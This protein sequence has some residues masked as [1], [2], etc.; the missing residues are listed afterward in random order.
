MITEA[1][2][3]LIQGALADVVASELGE[4]SDAAADLIKRIESGEAQAPV[5]PD[6]D[7]PAKGPSDRDMVELLHY[8]AEMVK[9]QGVRGVLE[10]V[11]HRGPGSSY[12]DPYRYGYAGTLKDDP[13]RYLQQL[14]NAQPIIKPESFAK[15]TDFSAS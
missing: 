11:Y 10:S 7:N 14:Y 8:V 2:W 12:H 5:A 6:A 9:R 13:A 4:D 3:E 1:D 15:L